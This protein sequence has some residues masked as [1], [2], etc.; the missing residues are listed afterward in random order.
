MSYKNDKIIEDIDIERLKQRDRDISDVVNR[1]MRI[2]RK[3]FFRKI[4]YLGIR[5]N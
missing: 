1:Y 2:K 3:S 4:L 5:G